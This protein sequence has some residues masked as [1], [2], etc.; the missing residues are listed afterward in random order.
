MLKQ[1]ILR[2]WHLDSQ[3]R[4]WLDLRMLKSTGVWDREYLTGTVSALGLQITGSDK[5]FPTWNLA[6]QS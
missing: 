2:F 5:A 1:Q 3:I 6:A 4:K